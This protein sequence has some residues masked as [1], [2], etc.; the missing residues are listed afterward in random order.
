MM[1]EFEIIPKFFTQKKWKSNVVLGVGDDAALVK[2]PASQELVIT[3]DTL[4]SEIHFFKNTT[5]FDIGYK[6]L[7]VNL[8]DLAA[9]GATPAW[10]T[11]S[12]TLPNADKKWI[13]EF[14]RGFF[15]LA[16]KFHV[17][18]IGGDLT[19][20]PLS[21][22]VTALGLIP[23]NKAITRSGAKPND[24]IFVTN[25][26]GDAGF[27][28]KNKLNA[29][30]YF[31]KKLNRP[32]PQIEIGKKLRGIANAAIDISDG[33]AADLNHILEKSSVGAVIFVDQ[34]PISK[35]LK[36][37]VSTEEAIHLAL[38]S[39]DDY[40]LCFTAPP[41]KVSQLKNKFTCIGYIAEKKGLKLQYAN[42]KEFKLDQLGYE[43]FK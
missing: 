21:I 38:T 20:G 42:E 17:D 40:E 39:G 14:A 2:I 37:L 32:F 26:L 12:L 5:A 6:S 29:S 18:L 10:M 1:N 36:K 27:A 31:L 19:R 30:D 16:K 15:S 4:V 33:L 9:M 11:L 3:T 41:K 8:S 7:A 35:E 23:K 28:V 25:T 22:T 34:L 24:K 13:K 43:H